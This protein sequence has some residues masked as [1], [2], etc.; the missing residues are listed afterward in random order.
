M[1]FLKTISG[2]AG[3]CKQVD[4]Y[5]SFGH[6][7]VEDHEERMERYLAGDKS[8]SRSMAFG[9]S[10]GLPDSPFGWHKVMDATRKRFGKD[11]PPEWFE[12]KRKSN[13]NLI[14]RN[15][16]QWILSPDP[17]DH[18]SAEEV[19]QLAQEWCERVWPADQGWQWI[20][21]VHDDNASGVM[22][23]HIILNAV[24]ASTGL[25]VQISSEDSDMLDHQA[26][27]I[28]EEHGM[29]FFPDLADWRAAVREGRQT[30][31]IQS[32]RMSAAERSLRRRGRRSWVAEIRDAIDTSIENSSDWDEFVEK[33]EADGFK[34]EWSRRGIG[35]RHP[36]SGGHDKKVLASSLGS[37]YDEFG[38]RAR[39]GIPVDVVT[40]ELSSRVTRQQEHKSQV[41]NAGYSPHR[42]GFQDTLKSRIAAQSR[43][44]GVGAISAGIKALSLISADGYGS[45]SEVEEACRSQMLKVEAMECEIH[46]IESSISIAEDVIERSKRIESARARI[47]ELESLPSFAQSERKE[48]NALLLQIDDDTAFCKMAFSKVATEISGPESYANEAGTILNRLRNELSDL[49]V[50]LDRARADAKSL[51]E[52]LGAIEGFVGAR[53]VR[54]LRG[55]PSVGEFLRRSKGRQLSV[56]TS[57]QTKDSMAIAAALESAASRRILQE[58]NSRIESIDKA[59]KAQSPSVYIRPEAAAVSERKNT[60]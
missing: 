33:F 22:H 47:A 54:D 48:R 14:W 23:A 4:D 10:P 34:V 52:S 7:S 24:N 19:G 49:S 38:I 1:P 21:S 12:K 36:D 28:G 15:Y 9:H 26:Q 13:P 6:R 55:V 59:T 35:Y 11:K 18:A 27:K 56:P 16:Y 5:L 39:L 46:E 40:G 3:S 37:S 51:S 42:R 41:P 32:V 58:S 8:A 43:R 30:P 31:T 60:V 25:K 53:A 17:R 20:W 45:V 44:R 29:N 50:S 2:G 57:I